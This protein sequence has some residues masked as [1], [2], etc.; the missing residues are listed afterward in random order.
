MEHRWDV[1]VQAPVNVVVH[2]DAGVSLRSRTHNI[3][4]GG[5][6]V[7]MDD[8]DTAAGNGD[9]EKKEIVWVE[10]NED[11]LAAMLPALVIRRSEK[12]A[13]LMFITHP[14]ALRPF[15]NQLNW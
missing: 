3:S 7:E 14:P 10:F 15:L 2:T 11:Q 12:T 9:I 13:A 1:R 4:H 6:F 8:P 5:I